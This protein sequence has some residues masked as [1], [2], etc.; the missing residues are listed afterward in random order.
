V[1][2]IGYRIDDEAEG[3]IKAESRGKSHVEVDTRKE[4]EKRRRRRR[5]CKAR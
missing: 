2:P 3:R 5:Q 1:H 4:R